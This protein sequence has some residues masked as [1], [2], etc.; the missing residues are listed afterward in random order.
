LTPLLVSANLIKVP[1]VGNFLL[2]AGENTLGQIRRMY[3]AK[4]S[5]K[6]LQD[7]RCIYISH[8]HA[9]HH[10]GT[11]AVIKAWHEQNEKN[12]GANS[13]KLYLVVP[14]QYKQ[15]LWEYSRI[16]AYGYKDLNILSCEDFLHSRDGATQVQDRVQRCCSDLSLEAFETSYAIHC[17]ASYTV[18]LTFNNGFKVAYSG[19]T[20]PTSGFVKIGKDCTLLIHEATFDDEL[21]AEAVQ[22]KHST[23]SDAITTGNQMNAKCLLLTH[24]SQRYPKLPV[25][26]TAK[27]AEAKEAEKIVAEALDGA[28]PTDDNSSTNSPFLPPKFTP[29]VAS[30]DMK[31]GLA[32]DMLHVK[33]RDFWRLE[34][35][36]PALRELFKHDIIEVGYAGKE[37]SDA[38]SATGSTRD[39]NQES[40]S[41][42]KK[43]LRKQQKNKKANIKAEIDAA[44]EEQPKDG[45]AKKK[46]EQNLA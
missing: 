41:S 19:D 45:K 10:L 17:L 24:F 46:L 26:E 11:V 40:K 2:D 5:D 33:I 20:R 13:Q 21:R 3:D 36:M 38:E 44:K 16:E 4:E 9:D 18:A 8:I 22:K 12:L 37:N 6:L 23:T 7:L 39:A 29:A 32:F 28:D 31:I 25:I 34:T 15:W 27:S 35:L 42:A 30:A 43:I 1:E 14:S